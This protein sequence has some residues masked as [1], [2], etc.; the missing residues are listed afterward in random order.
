MLTPF[1]RMDA[2]TPQSLEEDLL[3]ALPQPPPPPLTKTPLRELMDAGLNQS[4][5]LEE[6]LLNALSQPPPPPP[7]LTPFLLMDAI[8]PQS[9]EEDLLNALPQPPP[10]KP[11]ETPFTELM[12]AG[13]NHEH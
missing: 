12:D 5:S 2:I 6:D 4:S 7:L 10:P 9:L 1:S 13:L 8:T 3:N 11:L